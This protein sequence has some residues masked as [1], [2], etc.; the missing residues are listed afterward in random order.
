M[1]SH[2]LSGVIN[3]ELTAE[4]NSLTTTVTFHLSLTM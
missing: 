3:F 1:S 2:L 4:Y